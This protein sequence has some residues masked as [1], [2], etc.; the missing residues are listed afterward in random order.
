MQL[1]QFLQHVLPQEGVKCW[2]SIKNKKLVQK[3]SGT[4]E[5]LC[6]NLLGV[7]AG[8]ADAYFGCASFKD[9]S[10]RRG[11]NAL[12]AKSFWVD[13]DCGAEK[14][15]GGLG[16]ASADIA[17]QALDDF[18]NALDLP[19]PMVVRSGYGLHAYWVLDAAADAAEWL[20]V[21]RALK[22]ALERFGV[23]AD[24]TRTADIASILRPPE[25][26]NYKHGASAPVYVEDDH[27][28]PISLADFHLRVAAGAS[29][30]PAYTHDIASAILGGRTPDVT[31][32]VKE[33]GRNAACA[34][35]V[36]VL[37]LQGR[38]PQ[39][40]YAEALVWNQ[41]NQPPLADDEVLSVVN[42]ISRAEARKPPAPIV[43]EMVR[44]RPVLPP[45]FTA[46]PNGA[47]FAQVE[48]ENGELK[49]VLMCAFECYLVEVCRK[50]REDKESYVFTTYHP[51][52]GWHEFLIS[53]EEFEGSAWLATMGGNCT[54]IINPKMFKQYV[55]YAS[56]AMKGQKMDAV[57][58]EQFGWKNNFSAFLIG[59][60]LIRKGGATEFAYGDE[61][62]EPRIK[63]MKLQKGTTRAAWT[64]A[65]NR[66]YAPGFEAHGFGLLASFAAPLMAFVCGATDGGAILALHTQGSGFG[67][68][69]ILQA[70]A[71]VWG[72]YDA[73]AVSGCDTENA[74]FNIISKACHLP[75]YEEEM[76]KNDPAKEAAIIKRFVSGKDKNRSRRD[77]SVEYKDTRFQTIM[78]SASNHSLA[79]IVKASGD[80][81]SMARVIEINIEMPHDKEE[82][83]EFSKV[84]KAMLDNCGHAGREFVHALMSGDT[85]E[86]ARASL[87]TAVEHYMKL[88]ETTAKDRYVAYVLACCMVTAKIVNAIGVLSFDEVRI[89]DWALT[90]ARLRT[91]DT[92]MDSPTEVIGQFITENIMD[93]LVVEGAFV[94]KKPPQVI[95]FPK[96]RLVMRLERDTARLY[97]SQAYLKTWLSRA[98]CH[99][100]TLL[101]ALLQSE[102][103]ANRG[104]QVTLSAGTDFPPVR[105]LVWEI[106]MTHPDISGLMALVKKDESLPEPASLSF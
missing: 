39:Q 32:G 33:G 65:A 57:R 23:L 46:T 58:Y 12:C 98:N 13:I 48:N 43:L 35:F 77:G 17:L 67:K 82:F 3:F 37:L 75:V 70:V 99:M 90:Q 50:E 21:A 25:T 20:P 27:V 85:L 83:K 79:D 88:L 62:L 100:G 94:A 4:F 2:V 64:V 92:K 28:E 104:K 102:V 59:N 68:S 44:P 7:D 84:T 89:M 74:K 5:E 72:Q 51:H 53:R 1:I 31:A 6:A 97:I 103:L 29:R 16:Y 61:H 10:S 93:C 19:L 41:R 52:N 18:A 38:T 60:V 55:K 76:G 96:N 40:A 9:G 63:G 11:D 87:D 26:H 22:Q 71:S 101:K 105:T 49:T 91:E 30:A 45:G 42:S 14:A 81:G 78:I 15:A 56:V 69:N 80:Q 8:G 95:R 34:K 86:W 66:L 73:L 47:M 36:G 54:E 24:P 106:D